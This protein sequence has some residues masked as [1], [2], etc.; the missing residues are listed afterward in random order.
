MVA[1]EVTAWRKLN[2]MQCLKHYLLHIASQSQTLESG[3][4]TKSM[5]QPKHLDD[6]YNMDEN[7]LDL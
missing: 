4:T 2:I 3:F 7:I 6:E 5:V 1:S